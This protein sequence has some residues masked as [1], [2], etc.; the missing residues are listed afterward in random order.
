MSPLIFNFVHI[1][2]DI[3]FFENIRLLQYLITSLLLHN[4]GDSDYVDS[5][6]Q[7][8]CNRLQHA[9]NSPQGELFHL[10]LVDIL[11][12]TKQ[13][14]STGLVGINQGA[15]WGSKLS[16]CCTLYSSNSFLEFYIRATCKIISG[17]APTCDSAHSWR[18]YRAAQ[19]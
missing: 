18:H 3:L 19:L 2:L 13:G 5:C 1:S 7:R 10:Q 16:Q 17:W 11:C 14:Y 15:P 4:R 8:S 6:L 12:A 9:R